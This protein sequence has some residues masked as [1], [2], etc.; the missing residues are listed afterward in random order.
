MKINFRDSYYQES[1]LNHGTQLLI[2]CVDF[3]YKVFP[4]II[5]VNFGLQ[6]GEVTHIQVVNPILGGGVF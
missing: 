6:L 5:G 3:A 4:S 2:L 1:N